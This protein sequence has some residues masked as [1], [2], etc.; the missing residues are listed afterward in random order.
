MSYARVSVVDR[1]NCERRHKDF[2]SVIFVGAKIEP[3][4]STIKNKKYW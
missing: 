3:V 1:K 4:S 2:T